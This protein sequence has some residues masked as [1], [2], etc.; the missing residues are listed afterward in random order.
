[1]NKWR[2]KNDSYRLFIGRMLLERCILPEVEDGEFRVVKSHKREKYRAHGL[3]SLILIEEATR[4]WSF[5]PEELRDTD[6][7]IRAIDERATNFSSWVLIFCH[8][9]KVKSLLVLIWNDHGWNKEKIEENIRNRHYKRIER[10]KKIYNAW[11]N[12]TESTNGRRNERTKVKT[13]LRKT[14]Q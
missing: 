5:I 11:K 7:W 9:S 12:M 1:M 10:E 6:H 2:L 14:K 4:S 8:F 3:S 13:M